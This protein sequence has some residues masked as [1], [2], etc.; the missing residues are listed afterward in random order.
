MIHILTVHWLTD[1]WVDIQLQ[2]LNRHISVPFK[3]YAFLN[4]LPADHR[5][6][7]FYN[8]TEN[9]T[10]HAIKLNLLADMAT[11]HT[12]DENDWLMF[13][14]GDAFPIG[15]IVAFGGDKLTEHKLL[16]IRRSENMGDLQPHPSF[17]LT[18]VKGD[19]P[20]TVEI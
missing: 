10:S 18:T 9:I 11:L 1:R 8:S 19:V 16:A 17:C 6:K 2:Y 5:S 14:D 15:D 7:Y 13:L 3:V 20:L 12:R 4:A